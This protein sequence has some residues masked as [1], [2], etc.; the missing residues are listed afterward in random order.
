MTS[1]QPDPGQADSGNQLPPPH[2]PNL[3][4]LRSSTMEEGL[5]SLDDE[6]V[7]A[8]LKGAETSARRAPTGEI[9]QPKESRRI[10][11]PVVRDTADI[12]ESGI[13]EEKVRINVGAARQRPQQVFVR[14]PQAKNYDDLGALEVWDDSADRDDVGELPEDE[15]QR[16]TAAASDPVTP[17]AGKVQSDSDVAQDAKQRV[18][19]EASSLP[20]ETTPSHDSTSAGS[21]EAASATQASSHQADLAQQQATPDENPAKRLI[22]PLN[23]IER[24][25]LLVLLL[26]LVAG[27]IGFY[28]FSIRQLPTETRRTDETDFPIQGDRVSVSDAA[29]FW[30]IPQTEGPNADKVRRGTALVPVIE[31]SAG[32]QGAIRVLFRNEDREF[33]GDAV[34]LPVDGKDRIKVISTAGFDEIGMHAAYRTGDGR[35]WTATVY[36]GESVSAPGDSFKFLFEMNITT[37]LR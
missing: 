28:F 12:P 3:E 1:S 6:E 33:I 37:E 21:G 11:R 2:R 32:G 18:E 4:E 19:N 8:N 27:G 36:E 17:H 20:E 35:P 13:P 23:G 9:P 25:G 7:D 10:P 34:I 31:L 15:N 24:I 5:W 22:L 26:T 14:P 29:T 16:S 30:R